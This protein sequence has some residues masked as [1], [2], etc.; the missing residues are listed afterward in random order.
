MKKS[1]LSLRKL[2]DETSIRHAAL[3][4]QKNMKR[5]SISYEHME[6]LAEAFDITDMNELFGIE[7]VE[8]DKLK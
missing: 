1:G 8:E 5:Q 4:E 6:K 3:S 2:S 7:E